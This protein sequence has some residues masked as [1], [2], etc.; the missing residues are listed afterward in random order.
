MEHKLEEMFDG[1]SKSVKAILPGDYIV[2]L[3]LV[4]GRGFPIDVLT[5]GQENVTLI[6]DAFPEVHVHDLRTVDITGL[7]PIAA[8]F[9]QLPITPAMFQHAL[10]VLADDGEMM[11]IP[12]VPGTEMTGLTSKNPVVVALMSIIFSTIWE[13]TK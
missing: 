12:P 2:Y 8:K 4:V 13:R 11:W 6:R 5:F 1:A 9:A 10:G 3:G 7:E